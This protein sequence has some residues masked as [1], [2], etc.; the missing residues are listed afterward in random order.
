MPSLFARDAL[1][2]DGWAKDLRIEVDAAGNIVAADAGSSPANC[3]RLAGP[4]LPGM[5]NLHSHAFQRALAG[6]TEMRGMSNAADDDFWS[7]R[8]LMY[9]FMQRLTPAQAQAVAWQLY[10]EMLK[11][12]YTAVGEFHYVHDASEEMLL[13]HLAAAQASGI[14][15]ALLPSLYRWSNFGRQ[16]LQPRQMRF[17]S[18]PEFILKLLERIRAHSSPD[19]VAGVAPHSL[20]AVDPGSLKDLIQGLRKE[21]PRA[22]IHIHAAEQTRE[23][24]ECVVALGR[25]PVEWLLEHMGVDQRW[26]LVHATHMTP[27]ETAALAKSGATAGLC[28]T[29]EGNL[30]DGIFPLLAYR[31]A[32]GRYGIGGDSHVS[33]D[34]AEEL[35]LLEYAQRLTARRRNLVVG[36]RTPAVG[37]TLWLEAAAGGRALGRAMGAIAPGL[38]ADL[39]VLDAEQPDLA[40][41]S[42]DAIANAFIFSGA[43]D[44]VRDVM[45][46]GAWR[47]RDGHHPQEEA[48]ARG[49]K[50]ALAE[51]LA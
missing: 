41:R 11:H 4:V 49:Y 2:P 38:R 48:A 25:R 46:G 45:V 39:V 20:R 5:A 26:C 10:I 1:L 24:E 33:R 36:E 31:A 16:P 27:A 13:R 35:R 7:W 42:G 44:L 17:D 34:P 40:G 14:A 3:E 21:N 9:R 23:V 43:T 47:L 30:G 6:L 12:G 50:K 28:P 29:T 19:V 51:L 37:T 18:D 8:E 32:G 22:P 15:I